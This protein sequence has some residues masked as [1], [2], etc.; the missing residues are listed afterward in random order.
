MQPGR[1]RWS[2]DRIDELH[3]HVFGIAVSNCQ[4]AFKLDGVILRRRVP[5][6]NFKPEWGL[7]T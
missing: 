1:P 3:P 4:A 6:L 2:Q 7:L 5:A